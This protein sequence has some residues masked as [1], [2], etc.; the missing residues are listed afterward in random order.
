MYAVIAKVQTDGRTITYAVLGNSNGRSFQMQGGTTLWR[1]DF[2]RQAARLT[3]SRVTSEVY[4][5]TENESTPD[6]IQFYGY[7]NDL[8]SL[9][10]E[11]LRKNT[12][13][14]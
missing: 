3:E 2:A 13:A 1:T 5:Y 14:T 10:I 4:E 7:A 9:I 8:V 11:A 6:G 12:A